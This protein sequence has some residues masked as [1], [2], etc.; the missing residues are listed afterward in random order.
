[1]TAWLAH[2]SPSMIRSSSTSRSRS[3]GKLLGSKPLGKAGTAP[4]GSVPAPPAPA[5]P[6]APPASPSAPAALPLP[7]L[8]SPPLLPALDAS[9]PSAG[10]HSALPPSALPHAAAMS[11]AIPQTPQPT[12]AVF[13]IVQLLRSRTATPARARTFPHPAREL[14]ARRQIS[15]AAERPG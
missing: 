7:P 9:P 12:N 11:A 6:A 4:S 14:Q 3:A 13:L 5:A 10:A 2:V 15:K 1:M 8:L